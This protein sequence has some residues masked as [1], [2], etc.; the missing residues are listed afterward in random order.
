MIEMSIIEKIKTLIDIILPSPFFLSL[1]VIGILTAIL[2]II[3]NKLKSKIV[4]IL[5]ALS[6]IS[7]TLY[8]FI[9]YGP[10]VLQLSDNL[11]DKVFNAIYFP[12]IITYFCIILISILLFVRSII[13]KKITKIAKIVSTLTFIIIMFL[14][15]LTLDTIITNN[16]D[17]TLK[18]T[19]YTNQNLV[20]LI[21]TS[22][23]IFAI[24]IL[25][26]I[27]DFVVTIIYDKENKKEIKNKKYKSPVRKLKNEKEIEKR[28]QELELINIQEFKTL[29]EDDFK[30]IYKDKK[31]KKEYES[32]LDIINH[33]K[34]KKNK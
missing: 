29:S 27:I 30:K 10:S 6:Y 18:T 14:F 3:N 13:D 12:S 25:I 16:I 22:T 7:I 26:M 33:P 4:K 34:E 23:T 24:W 11:I 1:L 17:I 5:I 2:L 9:V 21:Q 20:V 15:I 28:M 8:I 32:Y 31:K 19:V